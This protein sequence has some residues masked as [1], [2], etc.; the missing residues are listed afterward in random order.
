MR[1]VV[2]WWN[3]TANFLLQFLP[4]WQ[5]MMNPAHGWKTSLHVSEMLSPSVAVYCVCCTVVH[6]G[7]VHISG[8]SL[9]LSWSQHFPPNSRSSR[10]RDT[11]IVQQ[12]HP[13]EH[14]THRTLSQPLPVNSVLYV[15]PEW[16]RVPTVTGAWDAGVATWLQARI[17]ITLGRERRE[18][19]ERKHI[20][21]S[22]ETLTTTKHTSRR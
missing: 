16:W 19:E 20:I 11:S 1:D 14:P 21:S 3:K 9:C 22:I 8:Q 2:A 6:F 18:R 10:E 15:I 5:T 17:H 4:A 12:W 7:K 13:E